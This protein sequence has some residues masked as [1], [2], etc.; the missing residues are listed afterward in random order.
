MRA[1]RGIGFAIATLLC[2]SLTFG[3]AQPP[4]ET[5]DITAKSARA[6]QSGNAQIL[7]LTGPLS[8][9]TDARR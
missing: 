3:Q 2:T 4:S 6:W 1:C 7:Q 5:F 8:I 9:S